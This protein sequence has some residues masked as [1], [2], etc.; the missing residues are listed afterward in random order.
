MDIQE[1][2]DLEQKAYQHWDSFCKELIYH[3]RFYPKHDLIDFLNNYIDLHKITIKKGTVLYRA[4]IIDYNSSDAQS[5]GFIKSTQHEDFG[6]FE[7]FDETNSFVP[8]ADFVG[9]GRANPEKVVYLYV[10]KE[11]VTAIAETRPRIFDHISVAKILIL[12]DVSL[13]DFTSEYDSQNASFSS[14]VIRELTAAFSTPCKQ[15]IDY[16]PT[17][18]I[19]EH[20]K[21]KGLAGIVFK[22]SYVPTG[23]N[24]TIF[25]PE[26]AKAIS[27]APYRLDKIFYR[28]RRM[29]PIKK[30]EDFEIIA[31]NEPSQ[32]NK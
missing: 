28:A 7:G 6:S 22:S 30:I 13:V 11:V 8:P 19:S 12:Q 9:P 17:Q 4:R 18:F 29:A 25:D 24:I 1:Q 20:I 23:T 16:V 3:N 31:T 15:P 10:A 21:S 26:I 32:Q 14:E 2:L 5:T 27:S